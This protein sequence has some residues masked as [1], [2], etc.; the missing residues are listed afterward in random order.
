MCFHYG[1]RSFLQLEVLHRVAARARQILIIYV[2]HVARDAC[3]AL[4]VLQGSVAETALMRHRPA[5]KDR[6]PTSRRRY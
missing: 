2:F 3:N 6:T 1:F 4:R 5:L